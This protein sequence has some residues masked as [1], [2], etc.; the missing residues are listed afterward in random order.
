METSDWVIF[1]YI[2]TPMMRHCLILQSD[3]VC[4][5]ASSFIMTSERKRA[6]LSL[7]NKLNIIEQSDKGVAGKLLAEM[8][9]VG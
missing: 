1:K 3:C 6:V 2:R 9:D 7:V 8:Y 4:E 5:C